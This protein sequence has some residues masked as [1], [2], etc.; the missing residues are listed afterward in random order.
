MRSASGAAL[1][2]FV[3]LISGPVELDASSLLSSFILVAVAPF[4]CFRSSVGE[5][6]PGPSSN[7]LFTPAVCTGVLALDPFLLPKPLTTGIDVNTPP[8][9]LACRFEAG[10]WKN[11]AAD[12]FFCVESGAWLPLEGCVPF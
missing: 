10:V 11:V 2:V 12:R 7:R 6:R 1:F 4:T 8:F 5:L 3:R 9:T